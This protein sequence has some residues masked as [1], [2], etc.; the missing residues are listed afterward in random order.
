MSGLLLRNGKIIDGTGTAAYDGHLLVEEKKIAAVIREGEP[1]PR[2]NRVLDVGGDVISPGFID[3]HSHVDWLLPLDDHPDILRCLVEQGVTTVVAGNCGFSPAPIRSETLAILDKSLASTIL[4]K[5]FDYSW[6]SMAGFL[7]RVEEGEPLINVAELAGHGSLRLASSDT[8]RGAMRP[9]ELKGCLDTAAGALDE[10]AAG[11]SFGLG[12]DPGMYSPQEEIE[13]FCKV[14][15]DAGKPVAVHL[16]ALSKIS[17]TYS[18]T[19]LKPHN[20]RALKEMIEAARKSGVKLQISHFIYVGRRSFDTYS[21]CLKIVDEAREEGIDVMIDA[22]AHTCGNT[23][24]NVSLPY[25]FIAMGPEAYKSRWARARLRVELELG[26]RLVGFIYKDFQIMDAAVPEWEELNGMTIDQVARKWNTSNFDAMLKI[27][28]RTRGE[29]LMLY[30]T[31]SGVPENEEPLEATLS[32]D[33]CLFETDALIK[34][35]GYPNP[36]AL[37]TFPRILGKYCREKKLFTIENAVKRMTSASAARFGIKD[38]GALKPGNF[39]DIVVFDAEKIADTPPVGTVPAG[40]PEGIS[41]VFINGSH[42]L[43]NGSF[44]SGFRPGK[45]LR[46]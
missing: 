25:W 28:E 13:A 41:H 44:T 27:S 35:K 10:G 39:A 46:V 34:S 24:I 31:Y 9:D 36:A 20:I 3:M 22:F 40:K 30:H 6:E 4:D 23:S 18:P 32:H 7:D 29:A 37:G 21:E 45:V 11:I 8:R 17:P 38:R 5:P 2:T 12:Y 42:M 43:D 19:Y 16:K 1:L 14:A 33:A 15:A 26:Y